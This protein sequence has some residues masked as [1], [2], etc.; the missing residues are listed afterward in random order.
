MNKSIPYSPGPWHTNGNAC[1]VSAE[2]RLVVAV[3]RGKGAGA[4]ARRDADAHLIAAAPDL[5]EVA[6][7]FVHEYASCDLSLVDFCTIAKAAKAAIAK[8]EGRTF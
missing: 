5:L 2:G 4:S 8:A 6:R 7:W 3:P 1:V